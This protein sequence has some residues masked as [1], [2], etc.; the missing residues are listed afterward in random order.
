MWNFVPRYNIVQFCGLVNPRFTQ[1][2]GSSWVYAVVRPRHPLGRHSHL[3]HNFL[4]YHMA[5]VTTLWRRATRR[6]NC[7]KLWSCLRRE[8][9]PVR[10]WHRLQ[11]APRCRYPSSCC[12]ISLSADRCC[13]ALCARRPSRV[14]AQSAWIMMPASQSMGLRPSQR[15]RCQPSSNPV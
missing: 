6:T 8:Q 12:A 7:G 10:E 13:S 3:H 4:Y 14:G 11:V 9:R 5:I 2:R 1:D 15:N